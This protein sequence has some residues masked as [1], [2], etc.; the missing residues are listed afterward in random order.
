MIKLDVLSN[1]LQSAAPP[2]LQ[3]L[4]SAT[5]GADGLL[6]LMEKINDYLPEKKAEIMAVK[7]FLE[8]LN[9][10]HKA[11]EAKYFPISPPEDF[12]YDDMSY[13][14]QYIPVHMEGFTDDD[15]ANANDWK[16]GW[17]ML[18]ALSRPP[19]Y[20]SEDDRIPILENIAKLVGE[21]IVKK[22]PPG[23]YDPSELRELIEM[24]GAPSSIGSDNLYIGAANCAAW[25]CNDTGFMILDANPENYSDSPWDKE[26]IAILAE[27][28]PLKEAYMDKIL[29]LAV[30]LEEKP[31]ERFGALVDFLLRQAEKKKGQ[32]ELDIKPKTLLEVFKGEDNDQKSNL[33]GTER[34]GG[35]AGQA[36]T[37]A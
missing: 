17:Q 37:A 3:S 13:W 2:L 23:G 1:R 16:D 27:Q 26:T 19:F 29:N 22:L 34:A 28:Y 36:A 12:L 6:L 25:M 31:R 33:G 9:G 35:T 10:F 18:F 30:Y 24:G 21:D 7:G 15:Y 32:L 14:F 8:R 20:G 11:F 5:Q 4:M